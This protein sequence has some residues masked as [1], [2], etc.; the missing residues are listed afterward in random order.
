MTECGDVSA[1]PD[2]LVQVYATGSVSEG[3][4]AKGRLESEGIPVLMKGEGEGPYPVG[5]VYLW[6]PLS[7]EPQARLILESLGT[8]TED[9]DS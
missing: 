8:A 5:P 3:Y 7:L 2:E 6:V 1:H 9:P 4:L